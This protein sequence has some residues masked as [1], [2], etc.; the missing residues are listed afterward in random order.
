M[1]DD[2]LSKSLAILLDAFSNPSIA[3]L[4]WFNACSRIRGPN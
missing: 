2:W 4:L 3:T 1:T